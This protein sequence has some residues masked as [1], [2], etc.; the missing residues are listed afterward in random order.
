MAIEHI[1][2]QAEVADGDPGKCFDSN[3]G[4]SLSY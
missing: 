2:S 4:E 1:K 3:R